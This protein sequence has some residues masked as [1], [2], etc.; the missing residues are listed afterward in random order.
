MSLYAHLDGN[1]KEAATLGTRIHLEGARARLR[2]A[3]WALYD[4][5]KRKGY[6]PQPELVE[7]GAAYEA[8]RASHAAWQA[9]G[10]PE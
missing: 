1:E 3:G 5:G 8:W 2:E 9:A 6:H 4:A 10:R 7:H